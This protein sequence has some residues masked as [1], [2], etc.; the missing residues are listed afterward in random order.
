MGE[1]QNPMR[2]NRLPKAVRLSAKKEIDLLFKTGKGK[3]LFP[4]KFVSLL[5]SQ[6]LDRSQYQA[7]FTVSSKKY[8]KAV[9]RNRIKRLMR[10]AF[11]LE[12]EP[13]RQIPPILIAYIY[14]APEVLPLATIRTKMQ[15]S[16]R[17]LVKTHANA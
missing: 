8:P 1:N 2:V 9:T 5:K 7:L 16:I 6:E 3:T 12:Q 10:E 14:I 11:R 4:L 15:E 17:T 13:L